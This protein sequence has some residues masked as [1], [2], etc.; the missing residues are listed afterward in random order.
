VAVIRRSCRWR[1]STFHFT[2]DFTAIAL[3]NNL[4]SAALDNPHPP[5]HELGIDVR[6]VTWKRVVD[7]KRPAPLRDITVA[8]GGPGNGFPRQDGFDIVVA[9]EV[10]AIFCLAHQHPEI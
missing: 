1:T 7:M 9:S 10:M 2:G 5:R 3:A 6:R 8:L 4:L